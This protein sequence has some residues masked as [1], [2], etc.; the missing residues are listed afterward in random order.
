MKPAIL[1]IE[2]DEALLALLV[3]ELETEAG[4]NRPE[5]CSVRAPL[6]RR[7]HGIS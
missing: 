7:A 3:D 6:L 1:L 2:D 5:I 4:W